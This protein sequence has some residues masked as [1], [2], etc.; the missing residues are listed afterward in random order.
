MYVADCCMPVSEVSGRQ[1]LRSTSRRKLNIPRFRRNT[2]GTQAVSVAD[3]IVWN[4]L[5]DSLRDPS[6]D[7]ERL[8]VSVAR[9]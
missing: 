3:P 9:M 1:H 4:S 7:A 2:F 5:P 6:V 8:V